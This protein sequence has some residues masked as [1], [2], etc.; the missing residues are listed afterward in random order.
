M[1]YM[2]YDRMVAFHVQR[3]VLKCFLNSV[4]D[5][6]FGVVKFYSHPPARF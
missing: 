2:L 1:N 4:P 3:G 6:I 5:S